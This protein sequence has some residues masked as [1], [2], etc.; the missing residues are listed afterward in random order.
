MPPSPSAPPFPIHLAAL[1]IRQVQTDDSWS[2]VCSQ[3]IIYL[4]KIQ[5]VY[6]RQLLFMIIS[7]TTIANWTMNKLSSPEQNRYAYCF[8]FCVELKPQQSLANNRAFVRFHTPQ[9]S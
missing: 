8:S 3:Q 1:A 7:D 4:D 9:M 5:T 6:C 2:L